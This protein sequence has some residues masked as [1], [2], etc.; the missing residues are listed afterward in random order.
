MARRF[1]IAHRTT[2]AYLGF[3]PS[4]NR[5]PAHPADLSKMHVDSLDDAATYST[6]LHGELE[7]LSLDDFAS[8]YVVKTVELASLH[9]TPRLLPPPGVRA[10]TPSD[11]SGDFD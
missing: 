3:C 7:R 1:V 11:P 9:D 6:F 10:R 5:D 4:L 8:A 2:G